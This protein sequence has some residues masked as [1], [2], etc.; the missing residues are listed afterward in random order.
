MSIALLKLLL[1]IKRGDKGKGSEGCDRSEVSMADILS[2]SNSMNFD[3]DLKGF[4]QHLGE[5][6][7]LRQSAVDAP[8][9]SL[10]IH[11]SSYVVQGITNTK[12]VRVGKKDRVL[13]GLRVLL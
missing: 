3:I 1:K 11:H 9:S 13:F 4:T 6:S 10:S 12:Y 7:L 8:Y 2:A 5:V